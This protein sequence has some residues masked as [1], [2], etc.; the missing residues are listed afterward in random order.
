MCFAPSCF[1]HQ[2][3]EDIELGRYI[4]NNNKRINS[5]R[6]IKPK[7]CSYY[8]QNDQPKPQ[9][10]TNRHNISKNKRNKPYTTNC[11]CYPQSLP[12]FIKSL[13]SP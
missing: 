4:N 11:P 9:S 2:K 10:P 8:H 1:F 13:N 12:R 7:L 6:Y 5:K 3:N